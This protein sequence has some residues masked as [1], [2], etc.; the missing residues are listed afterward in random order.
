MTEFT[1]QDAAEEYKRYR[2]LQQYALDKDSDV[3]KLNSKILRLENDKE[4]MERQIV[5]ISKFGELHASNFNPILAPKVI[6][7]REIDLVSSYV[8]YI[9]SF[10]P[11]A[12]YLTHKFSG[13]AYKNVG[14]NFEI[15]PWYLPLMT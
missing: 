8:A 12:R 6:S 14:G 2:S 15:Y 13:P 10:Y 4:M 11:K 5:T 7:T 1:K 3:N 9:I